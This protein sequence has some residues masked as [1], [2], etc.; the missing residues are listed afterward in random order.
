MADDDAPL[1]TARPRS[2]EPVPRLT[3]RFERRVMGSP[4]RLTVV[5]GADL[6]RSTVEA[7]WQVVSD[8]FDAVDLAMSRFRADSAVPRLNEAAGTG[9]I[10]RVEPRLYRAIAAADRAWRLTD[11]RFDP[12]VL[13]HLDRLGHR[14]APLPESTVT[15]PAGLDSPGSAW[16]E[17]WP[18]QSALRLTQTIDLGG[19]GKGLALRWAWRGLMALLPVRSQP[20]CLLDAGG[21]LIVA[22]PSAEGGPW[23]IGIEDP[24]GAE[25]PVAVVALASGAMCTSSIR[26]GRWQ[27]ADGRH[28]HHL[29]DPATGEPGGGGLV[30]VTVAGR[31]PAWSEVWSKA[32][33]IAG[34]RAIAAEA[35]G[36]GVAAWWIGQDGVMSMTPAARAST[37]WP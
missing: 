19:I 18:R 26:L 32:L 4:L 31:D 22:G 34:A 23:S 6:D 11:G 16:A 28:V 36:R 12:R 8:E 25:G 15:R 3:H 24:S 29:I 2:P 33:F 5:G 30:S 14:G 10:T 35:R 9:I 21:D 17:R 37:I 7:G 20:G 27:D 13:V 1:T